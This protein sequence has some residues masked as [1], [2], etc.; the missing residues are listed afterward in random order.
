MWRATK[1]TGAFF[2]ILG[3]IAAITSPL[4]APILGVGIACNKNGPDGAIAKVKPVAGWGPAVADGLCPSV[5]VMPNGDLMSNDP[6][7]WESFTNKVGHVYKNGLVTGLNEVDGAYKSGNFFSADLIRGLQSAQI[8]AS[9]PENFTITVTEGAA[10]VKTVDDNGIVKNSQKK[11]GFNQKE[12]SIKLM[13]PYKGKELKD[14][15]KDTQDMLKAAAA[16]HSYTGAT[17]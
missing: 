2:G 3:A 5:F 13:G 15:P 14:L 4:W 6:P 16:A 11:L 8:A 9:D 7:S 12:G 1:K 10:P 17:S